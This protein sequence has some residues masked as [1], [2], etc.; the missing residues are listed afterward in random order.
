MAI[1]SWVFEKYNDI[2]DDMISSDFGVNCTVYYKDENIPCD[3]NL[4]HN[5]YGG[6]HSITSFSCSYCGGSGFKQQETSEVIKLRIYF[7]KKYWLKIGSVDTPDGSVQ[8]F[9]FLNDMDKVMSGEY[10]ILNSDASN[11]VLKY[12]L[13]GEP[14]IHGFKKNR[15]F[16]AFLNRV[17]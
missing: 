3:C 17:I 14:Q 10:I 9:G 1:P 2:V 16:I 4:N 13:F 11:S 5:V 6:T 15:Y 12:K 8:V 7:D